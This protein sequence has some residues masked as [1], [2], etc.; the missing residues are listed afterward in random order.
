MTV[1]GESV[2]ML[3]STLEEMLRDQQRARMSV[4]A[5]LE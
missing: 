1:Q 3:T 5:A 4:R 2:K